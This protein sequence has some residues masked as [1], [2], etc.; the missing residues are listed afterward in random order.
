SKPEEAPLFLSRDEVRMAFQESDVREDE[1]TSVVNSIFQ[2][3]NQTVGEFMLPLSQIISFPSNATVSDARKKLL[4]FYAPIL[5]LFQKSPEHIV[6]IV[7]VRDILSLEGHQLLIEKGKSPWFVT[8]NTSVLQILDQFRRNNQHIAVILDPSGQA[9]GLLT[10]DQ[11]IDA[12]FGPEEIDSIEEE[13][14][15]YV[16]RTLEGSMR[17]KEFNRQFEAN[18]PGNESDTLTRLILSTLDHAPA[19]G[20]IVRIGS[21]EFTVLEPTLRG[22][23]TL[24]V[25]TLQE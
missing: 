7:S 1:F 14:G 25:R 15:H 10:L 23:K 13:P 9:C 3:K 20:E 12:M 5:P 22:I 17:I 19:K 2:L 11:M 8:K 4:N 16:A 24:S 21:Y 18:L 6:S